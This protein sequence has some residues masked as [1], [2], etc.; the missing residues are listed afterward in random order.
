MRPLKLKEIA[1]AIIS[2]RVGI[3][4]VLN[5]A[6]LNVINNQDEEEIFRLILENESSDTIKSGIFS[7]LKK[8]PFRQHCLHCLEDIQQVY[9]KGKSIRDSLVK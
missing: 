1:H 5:G 2:D 9:D 6:T 3:V 8:H 7:I 4:K